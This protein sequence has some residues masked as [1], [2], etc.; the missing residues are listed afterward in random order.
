MGGKEDAHD[1]S[2]TMSEIKENFDDSFVKQLRDYPEAVINPIVDNAKKIVADGKDFGFIDKGKDKLIQ[3][4]T[5]KAKATVALYST[6]GE[7]DLTELMIE[8]KD[9]SSEIL[10]MIDENGNQR[11]FVP[12]TQG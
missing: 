7:K 9:R 12:V 2:V 5:E 8:E 6:S 3:H 1:V 10:M 11:V 4:I